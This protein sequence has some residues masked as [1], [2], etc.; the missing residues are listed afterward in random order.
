MSEELRKKFNIPDHYTRDYKLT[1]WFKKHFGMIDLEGVYMCDDPET[2]RGPLTQSGTM[3]Y[4][5]IVL[6]FP[7]RR[8]EM[9][10]GNGK[11]C[12]YNFEP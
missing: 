9:V 3:I 5:D 11:F 1:T 7:D 6:V 10:V 4:D 8:V 2:V 12:V